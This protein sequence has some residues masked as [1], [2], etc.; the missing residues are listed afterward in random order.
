MN[1]EKTLDFTK[2]CITEAIEYLDYIIEQPDDDVIYEKAR[3][4]QVKL[5]DILLHL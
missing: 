5:R 3:D 4:A 1:T 2:G